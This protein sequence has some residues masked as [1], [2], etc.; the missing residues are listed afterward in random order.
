MFLPFHIGIISPFR[1]IY[2][3]KGTTI[4]Q[5]TDKRAMPFKLF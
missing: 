5:N 1:G 3:H 4:L 2:S